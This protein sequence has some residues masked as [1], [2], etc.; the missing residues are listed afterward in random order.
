MTGPQ[1]RELASGRWWSLSIAEQL[2]NV[3]SETRLECAAIGDTVNLASR[4]SGIA[5]ANMVLL[6]ERTV[7]SLPGKV[8]AKL[9]P[10]Q[11]IK[12]KSAAVNFYILERVY[13]E[14]SRKWVG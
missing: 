11:A 12:G 8:M 9:V 3:G 7:E 14:D 6:S 2:G 4:L 5:K 1:H 10:A 13:D